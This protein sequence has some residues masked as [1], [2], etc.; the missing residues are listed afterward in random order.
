MSWRIDTSLERR[1]ADAAEGVE[2]A[3][4]LVTLGDIDADD[5]LDRIDDFVESDR[6]ADHFA[7]RRVRAAGRA[8]ERDLVPLLA[9]LID[10][11]DADV[12]DRVVAAAVHAAR[13]LELDLAEVVQVIQVVEPLVDLRGDRD[14]ARIG[15]RRRTAGSG[16]EWRARTRSSSDLQG[17]RRDRAG[18]Q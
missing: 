6:R 15:E 4:F 13:H 14:R 16:R 10:A 2:E 17:P 9:A 7:E 3:L 18:R 1:H 11:E 12:A 8:A 5:T